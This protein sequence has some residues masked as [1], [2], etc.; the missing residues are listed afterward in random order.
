M[1]KVRFGV[2]GTNFISDWVIAGARQDERFELGKSDPLYQDEHIRRQ[3]D[4]YSCEDVD[5]IV[6]IEKL[7]TFL[8]VYK[9]PQ[10]GDIRNSTHAKFALINTDYIE[11]IK[12]LYR[13]DYQIRPNY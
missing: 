8:Q 11:E 6:P 5:Y 12:D 1:D 3:S 4:Y 7:D 13:L 10:V 9:I 2:V